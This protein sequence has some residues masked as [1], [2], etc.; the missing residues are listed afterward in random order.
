M[1]IIWSRRLC[2]TVCICMTV[3]AMFEV[4]RYHLGP[5]DGTKVSNATTRQGKLL[6]C[7]PALLTKGRNPDAT[8]IYIPQSV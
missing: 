8:G 7:A 6:Q 5:T 4:L 2:I 1:S 3:G